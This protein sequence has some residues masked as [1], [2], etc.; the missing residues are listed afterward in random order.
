M[1]SDLFNRTFYSSTLKRELT[2]LQQFLSSVQMDMADIL[3]RTNTVHLPSSDMPIPTGIVLDDVDTFV[4]TASSQEENI[5]TYT[6]PVNIVDLNVRD[7]GY[8]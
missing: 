2:S 4:I 1:S 8:F 3:Y 7:G 5:I 6:S